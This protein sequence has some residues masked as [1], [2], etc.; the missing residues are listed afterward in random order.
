M[1]SKERVGGWDGEGGD[2]LVGVGALAGEAAVDV[3]A[4]AFGIGA[5]YAQVVAFDVLMPN[6][7]RYDDDVARVD[8]HLPAL[9]AAEV[10]EGRAGIDAQHFMGGAVIVMKGIDPVAPGIGPVV[11]GEGVFEP[12]GAVVFAG[13]EDVPIEEEWEAA[14]G[15]GAVVFEQE[16]LGGLSAAAAA[17]LGAE[18]E[19]AKAK[20]A[21]EFFSVHRN[22]FIIRWS[23][24]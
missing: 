21:Q 15:D 17:A 5:D 22:C 24:L 8:L 12:A 6:P 18:A 4:A 16:L 14:V 10:Y 13:G 11:G 23:R 1:R 2:V 9:F 19:C 3:P 20:K 7:G